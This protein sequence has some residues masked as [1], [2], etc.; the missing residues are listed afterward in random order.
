MLQFHWGVGPKVEHE[1]PANTVASIAD[2]GA[3]DVSCSADPEVAGTNDGDVPKDAPPI[4]GARWAEYNRRFN[5][6]LMRRSD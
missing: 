1:W 4:T 3:F 2:G 5:E 6:L